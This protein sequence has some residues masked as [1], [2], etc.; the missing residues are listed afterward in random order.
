MQPGMTDR[1]RENYAVFSNSS[2]S[3]YPDL[4]FPQFYE[5]LRRR[6]CFQ[7][8]NSRRCDNEAEVLEENVPRKAIRRK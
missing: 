3:L 4:R 2:Y 7:A 5:S 8:E 6:F 1:A